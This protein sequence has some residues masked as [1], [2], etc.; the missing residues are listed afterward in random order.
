MKELQREQKRDREGEG[1]R[2]SFHWFTRQVAAPAREGQKLVSHMAGRKSGTWAIFFCLPRHVSRAA[3]SE[4][5]HPALKLTL[6]WK[7]VVTSISLTQ[8]TTIP[9]P[10]ICSKN[11]ELQR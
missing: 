5:K 4:I 8:C 2:A 11:T 9:D 6:L 10:R 1:E 3:G 7:A